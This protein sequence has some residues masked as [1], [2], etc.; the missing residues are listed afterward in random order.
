[1]RVSPKAQRGNRARVDDEEV[2]EPPGIRHVLV[3][4]E[5]EMDARAE[6]A[7]DRV[8]GVVDDGA[9]PSCTRHGEQVVVEHE[10]PEVRR[11]RGELLLDP[12]VAAPADLAV[13]EV[14]LGRVDGDDPDAALPQDGGAVSEQL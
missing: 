11:L 12:R 10:D 6:Q 13:V 3:S 5:D 14:V 2:L 7:L 9:L 8:A 4:G 1:S